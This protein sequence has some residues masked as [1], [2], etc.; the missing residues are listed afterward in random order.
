MNKQLRAALGPDL[1]GVGK[2]IKYPRH[3][4][5]DLVHPGWDEGGLTVPSKKSFI[6]RCFY[7]FLQS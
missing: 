3:Y 1:V 7:G 2:K 4:D 6:E 5:S